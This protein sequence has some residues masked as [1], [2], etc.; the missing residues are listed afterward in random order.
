MTDTS[1][2]AARAALRTRI[3]A[4]RRTRDGAAAA[5]AEVLAGCVP[6]EGAILAYAA[7]AGEPNLDALLDDLRVRGRTVY[8]PVT[9]PG[10]PLRFGRLDTAME[11]LPR[12]GRWQIREP[13]PVLT[14]P[15]AVAGTADHPP[16]GVVF[17]PGLAFS[18]DGARLGNGAGFYDR[19]FGPQ[20]QVPAASAAVDVIGVC[21]ADE[22][23]SEVRREEWDLAVSAI[24]T[25]TGLH[26]VT[27][28]AGAGACE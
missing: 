16:V 8:L 22:V 27:G 3:R 24:A 9:T 15:E 4:G 2:A 20:G 28:G 5:F 18:P 12:V 25:E 21:Y 26:P 19:T 6:S 14:A 23:L 17:V 11:R 13:E 7:L 1:N 10:Q